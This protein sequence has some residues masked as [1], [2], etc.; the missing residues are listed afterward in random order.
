MATLHQLAPAPLGSVLTTTGPHQALLS[1]PKAGPF[2]F[3]L[4]HFGKLPL[5]DRQTGCLWAGG[6]ARRDLV[7]MHLV[8]WGQDPGMASPHSPSYGAGSAL[9]F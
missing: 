3:W 1:L 9:T 2:Q 5:Y 4:N 6:G 7:E 8:A